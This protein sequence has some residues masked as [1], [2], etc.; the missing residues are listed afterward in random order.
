MHR[1]F[2][3]YALMAAAAAAVAYGCGTGGPGVGSNNVEAGGAGGGAGAAGAAGESAG[4]SGGSGGGI[5]PVGGAGGTGPTVCDPSLDMDADL[6]ADSIEGD[7]DQDKDGKP[8]A[9]D[10]DSD[11]D[12]WTDKEEA[13]AGRADACVPV[14]D[15]DN[16]TIPDYLD[17]D[18]DGDGMPDADER[19]YDPDGSKGCR[20]LADCDGDGVI[21]LVELAAGSSPTDPAIKPP[22]ATLYFILPFKAGEQTKDFTFSTGVKQADIYFLIDTTNTMAGAISNVKESIETTILPKLLNGD[23]AANPPIPAIPNAWVGVGDFRDIPWAP[24]GY[25][26]ENMQLVDDPTRDQVYRNSFK[27][28]D[29]T[30]LGNVTPPGGTAPSF[31]VPDNI[32][33]ILGALEAK[34]GGDSPEGT[35]QALWIAATGLPYQATLGGLWKSIPPTCTPPGAIGTPCFRPQTLPVFVL[36]TDAPFH[37]GPNIANAYDPKGT[38]GTK[39]YKETVD[40]AARPA[41]LVPT[42]STSRTRRAASTTTRRSAAKSSRW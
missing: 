35:T 27:V 1:S 18:S 38:G 42:C 9:T 20:V 15:T 12:G 14:A 6:I 16:D 10:D 32:K 11:G 8:N 31:T 28:G 24:Y 7:G 4:G 3:L 23:A 30:V 22:D 17:L 25:P 33:S 2:S 19:K 39:S 13:G 36:I 26:G 21:D 34:Q 41:R 5:N 29:Q 37:N 40:A